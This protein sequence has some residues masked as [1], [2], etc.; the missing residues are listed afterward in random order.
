MAIESIQELKDHLNTYPGST[1]PLAGGG[2]PTKINPVNLFSTPSYPY[3]TQLISG[4]N[5]ALVNGTTVSLNATKYREFS[6]D[7]VTPSWT[8]RDVTAQNFIIP[9]VNLAVDGTVFLYLDEGNV[10]LSATFPNLANLATRVYIAAI[11]INGGAVVSVYPQLIEANPYNA[12]TNLI[13]NNGGINSVS[14]KA[15][16][17]ANSRTIQ[18][19][20]GVVNLV[21]INYFTD[22]TDPH[23]LSIPAISPLT[24][25]FFTPSGVQIGAARNT[26]E[27]DTIYDPI[28]DATVT[29]TG[30][31]ACYLYFYYCPY[32]TGNK[33]VA[34]A[35]TFN[36]GSV[37]NAFRD[38]D[39]ENHVTPTFLGVCTPVFLAVGRVDYTDANITNRN[40]VVIINLDESSLDIAASGAAIS[41][42]IYEG[43]DFSGADPVLH[44]IAVINGNANPA[45]NGIYRNDSGSWVQ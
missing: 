36:H 6:G 11:E 42:R 39:K 35:G 17:I 23:R 7:R 25:D 40:Q 31:N 38:R 5:V 30:N 1:I 43:S 10:E 9:A 22:S 4:G 26:L 24:Y 44:S 13:F 32:R 12:S 37:N 14:L 27:F 8:D 21:G 15:T 19:S 45:I 3:F 2:R 16:P 28:G 20:A 18:T 29:V 34:I 41:S 33:Y